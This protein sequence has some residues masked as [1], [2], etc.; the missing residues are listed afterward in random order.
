[1]IMVLVGNKTDLKEDRLIEYEEAKALADKHQLSYFETS[2][3]E[4][5]NINESFDELGK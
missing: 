4:G 5:I 3:K 1:M 2:A